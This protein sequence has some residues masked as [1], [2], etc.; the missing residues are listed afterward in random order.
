MTVFCTWHTGKSL[1]IPRTSAT[2]SPKPTTSLRWFR[3][4]L[5]KPRLRLTG[6]SEAVTVWIRSPPS[7]QRC[8]IQLPPGSRQ[9]HSEELASSLIIKLLE[10]S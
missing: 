8:R 9:L 6:L 1:S 5:S 10:S 7:A 2:L 3:L 4:V